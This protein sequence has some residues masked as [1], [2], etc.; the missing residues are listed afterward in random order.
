M[1]HFNEKTDKTRSRRLRVN[2]DP[3]DESTGNEVVPGWTPP[4]QTSGG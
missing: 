3:H 1:A 2:G 4:S